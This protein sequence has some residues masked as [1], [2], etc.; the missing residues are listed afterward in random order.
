[1]NFQRVKVYQSFDGRRIDG[2][3]V[4]AERENKGID[5]GASL[6]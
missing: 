1:M 5:R 2:S 3:N 4:I 6:R